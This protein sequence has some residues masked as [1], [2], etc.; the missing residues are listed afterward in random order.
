MLFGRLSIHLGQPVNNWTSPLYSNHL[1]APKAFTEEGESTSIQWSSTLLAP[2][3]SGP[4]IEIECKNIPDKTFL[5]FL[6]FLLG[7]LATRN[8]NSVTFGIETHQF[9]KMNL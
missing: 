8:R 5:V 6:R 7:E 4:C 9:S 2:P 3:S 1:L